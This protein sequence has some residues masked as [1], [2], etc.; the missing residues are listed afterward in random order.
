MEVALRAAVCDSITPLLDEQASADARKAD[1]AIFYSISNTQNGL[2]GVS[3]GDSLI[4]RVVE[5]LREASLGSRPLPPCRRS[6]ACAPGWR[7]TPSACWSACPSGNSRR[8][9]AD[10]S[11][12]GQRQSWGLMVNYLY[13]LK[14]LDKHRALLAQGKEPVSG[15][16][17]RL[18]LK[19]AAAREAA[20]R[21]SGV[22]RGFG[23][24]ACPSALCMG[25]KTTGARH[26]LGR[27][28]LPARRCHG[29]AGGLDDQDLGAIFW[30]ECVP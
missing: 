27:P 14:R 11:P 9:A 16:V 24:G 20:A 3:F 7:R 19:A 18:F 21:P 25:R 5:T 17:E 1:T 15:D 22:E 10:P 13:D 8:W 23:A 28:L 26:F 2:R 30:T 29:P 12:R 4:K 6:R